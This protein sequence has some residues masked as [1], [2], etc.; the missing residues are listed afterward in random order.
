[1]NQE[2]LQQIFTYLIK[3]EKV[4]AKL[5][6]HEELIQAL[7]DQPGRLYW[8]SW[9]SLKALAKTHKVT[10]TKKHMDCLDNY[11]RFDPQPLPSLCINTISAE[12][13]SRH[14]NIFP[15]EKGKANQLSLRF[16]SSPSR[17][18]WRNFKDMAKALRDETQFIIPKATQIILAKGFHFTPTP[19]P[20]PNTFRFLL[21]QM[22]VKALRREADKRGLDHKGKKKADLVGQLSSG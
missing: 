14:L 9:D 5:L 19:P 3:R 22:T 6:S 7:A 8:S 20:V 12:E 4:L 13:L 16:S 2:E 21:Q 17:P 1:M 18:Y 11:F 15:L 10:I